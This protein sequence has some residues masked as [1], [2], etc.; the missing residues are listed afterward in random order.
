MGQKQLSRLSV[1]IQLSIPYPPLKRAGP[2]IGIISGNRIEVRNNWTAAEMFVEQKKDVFQFWQFCNNNIPD[3]DF[4]DVLWELRVE[5]L[6]QAKHKEEGENMSACTYFGDGHK[7]RVETIVIRKL[8]IVV[9][10]ALHCKS[11]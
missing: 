2:S 1:C 8:E 7:K 6:N 4:F 5:N 3:A 9:R 10:G 11:G